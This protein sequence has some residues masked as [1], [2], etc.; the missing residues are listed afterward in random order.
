MYVVRASF[1]YTSIISRSRACRCKIQAY[2]KRALFL[3][4][5]LFSSNLIPEF[6]TNTELF[7]PQTALCCSMVTFSFFPTGLDTSTQITN[8]KAVDPFDGIQIFQCGWHTADENRHTEHGSIWGIK[9][10][11]SF[12]TH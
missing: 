11:C 5:R 9:S 4:R 3:S 8:H 1:T 12:R 2:D 7:P 6:N 10:I